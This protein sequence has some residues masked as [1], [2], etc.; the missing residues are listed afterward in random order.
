MRL[1]EEI[2]TAQRRDCSHENE[3]ETGCFL[4]T[5]GTG[6]SSV[7][8]RLEMKVKAASGRCC[9]HHQWNAYANSQR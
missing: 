9:L 3:G 8:Q 7:K 1:E 5:N 6:N 2:M 4:E